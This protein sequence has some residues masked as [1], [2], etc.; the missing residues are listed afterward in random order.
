MERVKKFCK[1]L[2]PT[3]L[4]VNFVSFSFQSG[5]LSGLHIIIFDEIDAICKARGSVVSILV[6]GI[7][8]SSRSM[9]YPGL[10]NS[11]NPIPTERPQKTTGP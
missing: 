2:L 1:H 10:K 11:S 4:E 7:P 5:M 3:F 9:L 6:L 8:N